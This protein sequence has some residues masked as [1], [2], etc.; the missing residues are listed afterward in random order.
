MTM[1]NSW[2]GSSQQPVRVSPKWA[3]VL[4]V[5]SI[6]ILLL[7]AS[8]LFLYQ[9]GLRIAFVTAFTSMGVSNLILAFS[10]LRPQQFSSRFWTGAVSGLSAIM[11]LALGAT[12]AFQFGWCA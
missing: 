12:L 7:A 5:L 9:G 8:G 4:A 2:A 1:T 10:S 11:L 3:K 6:F